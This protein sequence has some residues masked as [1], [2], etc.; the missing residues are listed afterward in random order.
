[1][2]IKYLI[3]LLICFSI[4]FI[5][6]GC[7]NQ[8][9]DSKNEYISLKSKLLK[10]ERFTNIDDLPLEITTQVDRIDEEIIKYKVILN[11]PKENMKNIRVIVVH[12]YY[13]ENTFPTIGI[14]D[15]KKDLLTSNEESNIKLESTI[16]TTKNVNKIKLI[17][18]IWIEYINEQGLK[19][20]IIYKTT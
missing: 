10:E 9:E 11:H 13:N 14:F 15:E 17:L 19:K 16:K 2:K 20:E 8:E 12:N 6:T 3:L 7:K 18:K 4:S 1:M 5:I